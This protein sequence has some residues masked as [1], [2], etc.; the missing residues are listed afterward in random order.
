[1]NASRYIYPIATVLL[2]AATTTFAAEPP[3]TPT[4]E[5]RANMA[6]AHE[7]MAACLRSDRAFTDCQK[8]MQQNCSEMMGEQGC[9]M[10]GMGKRRGMMTPPQ[11]K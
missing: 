6:A 2:G 5:M 9:M 1:M 8:E 11:E 3:S 4:K 10:T 7:R